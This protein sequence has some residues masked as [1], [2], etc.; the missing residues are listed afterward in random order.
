MIVSPFLQTGMNGDVGSGYIVYLGAFPNVDGVDE[1]ITW[2]KMEE[3]SKRTFRINPKPNGIL[4]VPYPPPTDHT[5]KRLHKS[6]IIPTELTRASM[7]EDDLKGIISTT[8]SYGSSNLKVYKMDPR[9]SPGECIICT[10]YNEDGYKR[11][12]RIS[13]VAYNWREAVR[14]NNSNM[15]NQFV[16][17]TSYALNKTGFSYNVFSEDWTG[18]FNGNS[19]NVYTH[20]QLFSS[21]GSPT[22]Q[23]MREFITQKVPIYDENDRFLYFE[24]NFRYAN[25]D[26]DTPVVFKDNPVGDYT[27]LTSEI[28]RKKVINLVSRVETSKRRDSRDIIISNIALNFAFAV[29]LAY[30]PTAIGFYTKFIDLRQET[31]NYLTSNF[32]RFKSIPSISKKEKGPRLVDPGLVDN[33]ENKNSKRA[34]SRLSD[35]QEF[36]G[37]ID[38]QQ[39][40]T[41]NMAGKVLVRIFKASVDNIQKNSNF[42]KAGKK[43]SPIDLAK[44]NLSNFIYKERGNSLYSLMIAIERLTYR[45]SNEEET[46]EEE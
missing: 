1:E 42:Q 43:L 28:I 21:I 27:V 30:F 26:N 23:Q 10:Y 46:K 12:V 7:G 31:I 17:L 29:P 44:S 33:E 40:K 19:A 11:M 32:L 14:G 36:T 41:L 8:L 13:P 20:D 38:S 6:I 39:R 18:I 4:T 3:Y 34:L 24:D 16:N 25:L 37:R 35:L 15:F 9:L 45:E 22:Q 2:T 5:N